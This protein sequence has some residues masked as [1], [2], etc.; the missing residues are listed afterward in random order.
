MMT[1]VKFHS[2]VGEIER[3]FNTS[4]KQLRVCSLRINLSNICN[5]LVDPQ[6]LFK[7]TIFFSVLILAEKPKQKMADS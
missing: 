6:N 5:L 4:Q 2:E 1:V 7:S 3:T